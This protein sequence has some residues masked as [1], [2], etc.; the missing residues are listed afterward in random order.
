M[1]NSQLST[2][3]HSKNNNLYKINQ[4]KFHLVCIFTYF[5]NVSKAMSK[6]CH[7]D[8]IPIVYL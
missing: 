6:P 7:V 8:S 1:I 2:I 5:K 3:C 4:K